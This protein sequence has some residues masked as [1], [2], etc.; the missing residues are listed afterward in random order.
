M[1]DD[2]EATVRTI[3][4]YRMVIINLV[5]EHNGR[6]VDA[7]GDNVLAEFSSV[8]DAVRCSVEVQKEL[9]ARNTGVPENRRMEF[10]IGVNLGDVIKEGETIYGDGVNVAARLEGLAEPGGLCISGTA[11]D[12]VRDRLNLGY[13]YL[14]EQSV[15]N[16]RRPIRT[17]KVLMEHAYA[18]KVVGE[19]RVKSRRWRLAAI[20]GTLAVILI[21][22][23]LAIWNFYFRHSH[24]PASVEKMAFP[25]P[26]VPSIAVLP[27]VNLSEDPK[28]EFFSDAITENIITALSKVPRLFVISRQSTFFYKGKPVKIKQVSEE[29]GV[30]FVLEGSVQMYANRIRITAQLIDAL[31]GRH[32]WAER[33][34]R[35]QKDLFA[36]QD[37]IT[38]RILKATQVKL[39]EGEISSTY[40]Q[41]FSG[42][43]G[44]D[45]YLKI[46]EASKHTDRF[47]LEDFDVARRLLEE[48][49]S[50][51]P[52]NPIG[53]LRLGMVYRLGA[54]LDKTVPYQEVLEKAKELI[55]KALAMDDTLSD[56]HIA[57]CMIYRSE[58]EYDKSIAEGKRAVELYPSG[59]TAYKS[60]GAAL[61]FASQPRDAL[62]L[63]QKAIRLNPNSDAF[64]FIFLGHAFRNT[65]QFEE[66]VSA[67]K[68][69]LQ[70]AP[71][72]IIPHIAL[73]TV[74]SLM[75]REEEARAEAQ[76]VLRINP[77]FSLDDFK[78]KALI[79]KD[80]AENNMI[81]NAMTKALEK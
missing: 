57:L 47:T 9:K 28:Q 7:K 3:N 17:Y 1:S 64:T 12:H 79:F 53:F 61:L 51:C 60:Y 23:A 72:H 41:Y 26:E 38:M 74:Y 75:D 19:K 10:R 43:H 29:F 66:A 24:E 25:L 54:I 5:E 2:E 56:A 59:S 40:S 81:I 69:A 16:I 48:T 15:K 36:V 14:G 13:E 4:A 45:C 65:G 50:I 63:I 20:A 37:E 70:R 21:V 80:E 62:P 31:T 46:L 67:Y 44:F 35:D 30:Q 78:K 68:T 71:D 76:E 49:I 58:K 39:S 42:K 18:G 33:Y 77:K 55:K 32:L 34:E 27:F 11:F 8:V 22:G 73:A 6:V 52:E